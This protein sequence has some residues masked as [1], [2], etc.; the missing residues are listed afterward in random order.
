M[1]EASARV[2]LRSVENSTIGNLAIQLA[3]VEGIALACTDAFV[4]E[5]SSSAAAVL[6][7]EPIAV[8]T[9]DTSTIA[10]TEVP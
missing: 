5:M 4:T 6:D 3:A 7:H 8:D 2:S 10:A 9:A 1:A